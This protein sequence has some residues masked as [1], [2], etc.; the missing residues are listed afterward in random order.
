MQPI[1]YNTYFDCK[2]FK[3]MGLRKCLDFIIVISYLTLISNAVI[4]ILSSSY[5]F[6]HI[7]TKLY[8]V[9]LYV[10]AVPLDSRYPQN[11]IVHLFP[12]NKLYYSVNNTGI[13]VYYNVDFNNSAV[14]MS[15][16]LLS[17]QTLSIT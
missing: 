13:L 7:S 16:F 15:F 11:R 10:A 12:Y 17:D 2:K 1:K 8:I 9:R 5:I 14:S 3:R 4:S 6:T